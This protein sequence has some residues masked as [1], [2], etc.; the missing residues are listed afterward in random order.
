M[1]IY[2]IFDKTKLYR[3]PFWKDPI[4]CTCSSCHM[5]REWEKSSAALKAAEARNF[6]PLGSSVPSVQSLLCS[7][8]L[9]LATVLEFSQYNRSDS[10]GVK[11][12]LY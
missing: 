7:G 8:Q 4:T 11:P 9:K 1:P 5:R 10:L 3:C 6:A 2:D 12:P